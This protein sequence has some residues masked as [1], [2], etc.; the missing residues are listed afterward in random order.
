MAAHNTRIRHEQTSSNLEG[1]VPFC[2]GEPE[3]QLP[4]EL[5]GNAIILVGYRCEWGKRET[6]VSDS[7][8]VR[9]CVFVAHKALI[10]TVLKVS[11]TNW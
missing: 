5:Q 9:P 2:E 8:T 1:R 6:K 3:A 10:K 11:P 7:P 4:R